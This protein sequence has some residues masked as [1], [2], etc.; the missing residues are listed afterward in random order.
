MVE[1]HMT[2]VSIVI[3]RIWMIVGISIINVVLNRKK[4][5]K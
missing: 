4:K 2:L 1:D 3:G 5:K